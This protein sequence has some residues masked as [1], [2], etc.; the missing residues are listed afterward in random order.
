MKYKS[1][2]RQE[3]TV[4]LK[5]KKIL[6]TKGDYFIPPLPPSEAGN[7]PPRYTS[8]NAGRASVTPEFLRD[9]IK[10]RETDLSVFIRSLTFTEYYRGLY[11]K[12][13]TEGQCFNAYVFNSYTN[14]VLFL[15]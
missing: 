6:L 5:D 2:L 3:K 8:D 15:S 14:S 13:R 10:H 4:C 11:A 9:Q 12:E 7:T 1:E